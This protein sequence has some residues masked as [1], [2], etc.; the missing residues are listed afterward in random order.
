MRRKIRLF[1]AVVALGVAGAGAVGAGAVGQASAE[2]AVPWAFVQVQVS[3]TASSKAVYVPLTANC[4]S[5]FTPISGGISGPGPFVVVNEYSS[6]FNDSFSEQILTEVAGTYYLTAECARADQVGNIQ[7]VSTNFGRNSSGQ[8]GGWV[9]C[10]VGTRVIGGG[11]DWNQAGPRSIQYDAPSDDGMSWYATGASS[12]GTNTLHIEAYCADSSALAAAQRVTQ[13]YT[14]PVWGTNLQAACPTNT[15]TLTGGVFAANAGSGVDPGQFAGYVQTALPDTGRLAWHASVPWGLPGGATVYVTAWCVPASIPTVE[16]FST[17][18]PMTSQ[19]SAH[20]G[21]SASDP[22]G[23]QLSYTCDLDGT[24]SG[25]AG[26]TGTEYGP[27]SDGAHFFA[28]SVTNADGETAVAHY[29]WTVDTIAPKV[30]ATSAA[31]RISLGSSA[32]VSWAG[33]DNAGGTGIAFYQVRE[34][35]AGYSSGF[36]PWTYPSA[37]QALSPATT[38]VTASGLAEG[39]DYC[40]AVRAVDHAGNMSAWT[41][42]VC[43]ARPLDDRSLSFSRGW[44][45]GTGSKY[46]NGTITRTTTHKATGQRTGAQ[47]DRVGI[48]AT[49]GP[50]MGTIAIYVGTTRIGTISLAATSTHYRSVILLPPFSYRAG[51]VRV[52]VTSTAK[53]VQIDGLEISRS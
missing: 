49:R 19:T 8:A 41:T 30:A 5:G 53:P 36:T 9:A 50:G 38:S 31:L 26:P 39:R 35:A 45:R 12:V 18:P 44:V 16:I 22:A 47:L 25:C 24:P 52:K 2:I 51:T 4:P 42:P 48:I 40:F 33:Q 21:F 10:P 6:F 27:L 37:W 15:R 7:V 29:E 17:P 14:D 13:A 28:V 20:F 32:Q 43:T 46:W 34:R 1:L 11:A 3:G 23:Y